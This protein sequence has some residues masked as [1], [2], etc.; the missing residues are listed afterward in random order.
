MPEIRVQ[1]KFTIYKLERNL[2][3]ENFQR[4][5]EME[6]SGESLKDEISEEIYRA[7]N[8]KEKYHTNFQRKFKGKIQK[9]L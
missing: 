9:V 1:N 7:L 6:V 8:T 5:I 4:K 3:S 2:P